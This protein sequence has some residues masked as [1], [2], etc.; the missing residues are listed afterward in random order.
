M[1]RHIPTSF[2][3]P[4]QVGLSFNGHRRADCQISQLTSYSLSLPNQLTVSLLASC[5]RACAA[6]WRW[7]TARPY[8]VRTSTA[9]TTRSATCGAARHLLTRMSSQCSMST[10][11]F[12]YLVSERSL[13]QGGRYDMCMLL[14]SGVCMEYKRGG[15]RGQT[16]VA[17]QEASY[18]HLI[19]LSTIFPTPCIPI[20]LR[21]ARILGA[22]SA[23]ASK[24]NRLGMFTSHTTAHL[25]STHVPHTHVPLCSAI[26][27]TKH[28]VTINV[29]D[30]FLNERVTDMRS[31][32]QR[33]NGISDPVRFPERERRFLGCVRIPLSAIYQV[34]VCRMCSV[35]ACVL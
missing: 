2:S 33:G 12:Q 22:R 5:C 6:L 14:Y 1:S 35:C 9:S 3:Q 31:V 26:N 25:A 23:V 8:F 21:F 16:F 28:Y 18:V 13:A 10:S 27:G 4:A 15:E 32:R 30:E 29:F 7:C 17:F 34:Q 20:L 11:R 24:L 19:V